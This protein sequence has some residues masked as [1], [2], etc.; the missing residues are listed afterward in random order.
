[1][2]TK[3]LINGTL[4]PGEGAP[5]KILDPA[6]GKTIAE[7]PEASAAQVNA[8]VAAAEAAARLRERRK[9]TV[10]PDGVT[11]RDLMTHGR[12]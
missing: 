2:Q 11:I 6:T 4:V 10:L 5:E 1:M 8:A 12:A 9:G 3:F 7:V